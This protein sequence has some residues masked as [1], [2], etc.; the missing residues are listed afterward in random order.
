MRYHTY[1]CLPTRYC[2]VQ[3]AGKFQS[4]NRFL[5]KI[6]FYDVG[7][8]W[9]LQGSWRWIQ[10]NQSRRRYERFHPR[11]YSFSSH[12]N[13]VFN[14]NR[15]GP[16]PSSD[17]PLKVSESSVSMKSSRMSTEVP[18]ERANQNTELLVSPFLLL[19]PNSSLI[20]SSAQWKP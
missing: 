3:N 16:Q 1:P 6:C 8:P 7:F 17:T 11:K 12:V 15:D 2:Q 19:A 18:P 20:V 10:N 14:C 4:H 13:L 9:T 5:N